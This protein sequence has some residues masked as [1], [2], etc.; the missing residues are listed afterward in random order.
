MADEPTDPQPI[1][2]PA[3]PTKPAAYEPPTAEEWEKTQAALRKANREAAENRVKAQKLEDKDKTESEK[4]RDEVTRLT[5]ERDAQAQ[6]AL[7]MEIATESG[8]NAAQIKFLSGTSREELEAR[9]A[10]ILEA[11]P[12]VAPASPPPSTQPRPNLRGGTEPDRGGADPA[13]ALGDFLQRQLN[14]G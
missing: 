8:L 12:A 10:E 5:Q 11:M 7:R 3:E 2:D 4:L 13:Q 6:A 9:A 1:P 14:P